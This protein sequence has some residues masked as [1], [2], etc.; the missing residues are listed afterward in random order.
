MRAYILI[1]TS[2]GNARE[3]VA[4]LRQRPGVLLADVINGPHPVIALMEDDDPSTIAQAILFDIRRIKGINDLTVYLSTEEQQEIPARENV[5]DG[6]VLDSSG[7][8]SKPQVAD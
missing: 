4:E 7:T 8:R 6:I 5:L 2:N 3:I 1:D